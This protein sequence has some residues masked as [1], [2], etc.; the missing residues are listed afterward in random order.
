MFWPGLV[1]ACIQMQCTYSSFLAHTASVVNNR[2]GIDAEMTH[3][4]GTGSLT[5]NTAVES[6]SNGEKLRNSK[7]ACTE[8]KYRREYAST[9]YVLW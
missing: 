6:I 5:S 3:V 1:K 8:C 7:D 4:P 9:A 2:R